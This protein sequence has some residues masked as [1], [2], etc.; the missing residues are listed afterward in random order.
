MIARVLADRSG[1]VTGLQVGGFNLLPHR[2]RDARSLRRRRSLECVA[3]GLAG[4]AAALVWTTWSTTGIFAPERAVRSLHQL[5]AALAE[6]AAPVAEYRR[7]ERMQAQ[8]GANVE[9][10]RILARPRD[11]LWGVVDALRR[12]PVPGIALEQL[13][14]SSRGI[15]IKASAVDAA[16]PAFLLERLGRI[17]EV[18]AAELADLRFH[19]DTGTSFGK[20]SRTGRSTGT[21]TVG[22]FARLTMDSADVQ[23]PASETRAVGQGRR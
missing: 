2:Q 1:R 18:S 12:E 21:G 16:T 9:R 20:G 13:R 19:S 11:A 10:S 4:L 5:E 14:L 8:M 7:L 17:P 15:E 22:F 6:L 3:A 23:A